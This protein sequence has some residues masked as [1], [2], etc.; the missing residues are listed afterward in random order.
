[1]EEN[2]KKIKKLD[3]K[4]PFIE[5]HTD[6]LN[7]YK[8]SWFFPE[9]LDKD[10]ESLLTSYFGENNSIDDNQISSF[11][12]FVHKSR[13][14]QRIKIREEVFE[15]IET[16]F[17]NNELEQIEQQTTLD[18]SVIN[19]TLYPYQKE[20]ILFSVFKKGVII[21]DEMGLGKTIQ[22]IAT[23]ILKKEDFNVKRTLV[24]CPASV[25][26]QWKNEVLKFSNEK[27]AVIEGNPENRN[28]LYINDDSFFHIINYETV[29]RDL[30][31]INKADYDFVILDEAQ[32]IKNYETQT[33]NAVKR[34]QKKHGLV[35]TGTPLE[36]KLL[37]LYSI[38]QFLDQQFLSPQ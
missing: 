11:F 24:I 6:P 36:N 37:D 22:A 10:E 19:A 35:I 28:N 4:Y 20:G 5:I 26:H 23:A 27:A 17:E 25:K 16:Y 18:F 34:I 30:S 14:F 38:V 9:K 2:P 13:D 31:F 7:D 12:S 21:A 3:K 33:A 32:K 15:K 1:M 29:L 8:I